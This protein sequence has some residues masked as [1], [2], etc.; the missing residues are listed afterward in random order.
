M[1]DIEAQPSS[2]L[3]EEVIGIITLEDVMEALLQVDQDSLIVNNFLLLKLKPSRYKLHEL[4]TFNEGVKDN[5]NWDIL[6]EN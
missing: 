5:S 4:K 1:K 6:L 2:T 3:D